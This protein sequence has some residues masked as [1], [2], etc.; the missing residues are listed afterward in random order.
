M[1]WLTTIFFSF[2]LLFFVFYYLFFM[3]FLGWVF[4]FF[5]SE[6]NYLAINSVF[7]KTCPFLVFKEILDLFFIFL[8]LFR[9]LLKS[10]LEVLVSP[11]SYFLI[12]LAVIILFEGFCLSVK[13]F[14]DRLGITS[15]VFEVILFDKYYINLILHFFYL[16]VH[17]GNPLNPEKDLH[18]LSPFYVV[19]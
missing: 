15:L 12:K 1:L 3:L 6:S 10:F 14:S 11:F 9:S 2:D 5:N 19:H 7:Y 18:F 13:L 4:L 8:I 16:L 17:Y